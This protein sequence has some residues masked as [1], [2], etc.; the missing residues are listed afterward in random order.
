MRIFLFGLLSMTSMA[1]AQS[2]YF[3]AIVDNSFLLEEAYNQGASEVQHI[4]TLVYSRDNRIWEYGF[5]QEWPMIFTNRPERHQF[6]FT[7]P[8]TWMRNPS[9]SGLGDIALNYRYQML[10]MNDPV[11]FTPRFSV[12]LAT[13]NDTKG[14]GSGKPSYQAGFPFS[15]RL[16]ENVAAHLNAGVTLTPGVKNGTKKE[17][18]KGFNVGA[19]LFWIVNSNLNIFAEYVSFFDDQISGNGVR[20]KATHFLNPGLCYGIN[21]GELQAVP[22][23]SMPIQLNGSHDNQLFFYLSLEHPFR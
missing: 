3:E 12:L 16:H 2:R 7:I 8:Y 17:T 11:A 22:G 15:K 10:T 19:S 4:S 13:G 6:S 9:K 1:V 18:L 21:L 20:N 14:L 23:I 5:T